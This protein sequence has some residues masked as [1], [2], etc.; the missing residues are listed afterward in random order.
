[1]TVAEIL[2]KKKPLHNVLEAENTVVDAL[3]LMKTND[4]SYIIALK[5]GQYAGI[6]SERDY[7]QKVLLMGKA[8]HSTKLK[9]V[10]SS[11][12]PTVDSTD[13]VLQCMML[14]NA[15]KTRFLPVFDSFQFKD[16]VSMNDLIRLSMNKEHEELL[17]FSSEK[18]F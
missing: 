5:N 11:N 16:V 6:F 9:D 2:I 14:M 1:M 18:V 17:S 7:A 8:A 12:L 4:L 15:Y 10:M 3:S 13:S